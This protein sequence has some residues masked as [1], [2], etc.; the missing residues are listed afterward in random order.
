MARNKDDLGK[1]IGD[2][3]WN[4]LKGDPRSRVWTD[5]HCDPAPPGD[6]VQ[7]GQAGSATDVADHAGQARSSTGF[8]QKRTIPDRTLAFALH[9]SL[10]VPSRY[11]HQPSAHS[12]IFLGTFLLIPY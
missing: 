9:L 8:S 11:Q 4:S 7:K 1:L 6:V 2:L 5:V 12:S 10:G 3:R